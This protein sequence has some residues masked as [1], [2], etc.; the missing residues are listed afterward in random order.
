MPQTTRR[1][2]FREFPERRHLSRSEAGLLKE[3]GGEGMRQTQRT[4]EEGV[5][6]DGN[7]EFDRAESHHPR[8][9]FAKIKQMTSTFK[10]KSF[11][12]KEEEGKTLTTK[13]EV[14]SRWRS[15]CR[16]LMKG[17]GLN[18]EMEI[19]TQLEPDVL[20]EEMIDAGDGSA[21]MVLRQLCNTI[22]S[23]GIWP[24]QHQSAYQYIKKDVCSNYRTIALI[25]HPSKVLLHIIHE[26]LKYYIHS[27][28]SQEQTGFM[29]EKGTREQIFTY[30]ANI[31]KYI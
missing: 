6:L 31:R 22:W 13:Q 12:V 1:T 4:K 9:M 19:P 16:N 5:Y 23:T 14:A 15:Y 21:I 11:T 2:S 25:S 24:G 18:E 26:R 7:V 17:T 10:K 8:E 20:T 27:Q 3:R 28:I 29:P 30:S